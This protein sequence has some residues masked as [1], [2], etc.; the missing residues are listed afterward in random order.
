MLQHCHSLRCLPCC[1][2]V[3]GGPLLGVLHGRW[4]PGTC[5]QHTHPLSPPC[6]QATSYTSPARWLGASIKTVWLL[7]MNTIHAWSKGSHT[8]RGMVQR[9]AIRLLSHLYLETTHQIFWSIFGR[10]K[11]RPQQGTNQ[12]RTTSFLQGRAS[13]AVRCEG[14]VPTASL[15]HGRQGLR[16]VSHN[17]STAEQSYQASSS[18]SL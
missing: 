13:L 17:L 12:A 10:N 7:P 14:V 3:C 11:H 6:M 15:F 9:A 4:S 16:S 8:T 18:N 1:K 5:Q 2:S